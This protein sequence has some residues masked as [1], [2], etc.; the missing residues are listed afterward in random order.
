MTS[1]STKQL[2]PQSVYLVVTI[3]AAALLQ[4]FWLDF[5]GLLSTGD[6]GRDLYAFEQTSRGA[7]PY[8]DYWW[9]YGPLMPYYYGLFIKFFGAS[10]STVLIAKTVIK[11]VAAIFFYLSAST[12]IPPFAAFIAS[13]ELPWS[14]A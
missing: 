1:P 9:V 14:W 2:T 13:A 3:I 10:I 5:Q 11:L 6:H 7:V 12:V 4:A 8:Q